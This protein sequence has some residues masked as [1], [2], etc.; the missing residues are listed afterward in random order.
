MYIMLNRVING[1]CF[2][3]FVSCQSSKHITVDELKLKSF[4]SRVENA[5]SNPTCLLNGQPAMTCDNPFNK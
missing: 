1:P 2:V 5:N 4:N 3:D